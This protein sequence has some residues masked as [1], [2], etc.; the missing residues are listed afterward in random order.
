MKDTNIKQDLQQYVE[1]CKSQG[2]G[3]DPSE[4]SVFEFYM[5]YIYNKGE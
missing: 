5:T 4:Y 2:T 3:F 1:W